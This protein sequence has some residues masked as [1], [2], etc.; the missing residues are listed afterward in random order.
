MEGTHLPG[1]SYPDALLENLTSKRTSHKIA[2]QGRRDRINTALKEIES[3]L[4]QGSKPPEAKGEMNI[5]N[6]TGNGL[7]GDKASNSAQGN[8]KA[9]SVEMA[10]VYIRSLQTE[11][12]DT[13]AKLENAEKKLAERTVAEDVGT[14]GH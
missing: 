5:S 4:P 8:S 7:D 10:I 6:S 13:K 14:N 3:L 12:A 11:L 1:V 2:E 9:S